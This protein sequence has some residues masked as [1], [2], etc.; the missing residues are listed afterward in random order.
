MRHLYVVCHCNWILLPACCRPQEKRLLCGM[1]F[2]QNFLFCIFEIPACSGPNGLRT[3]FTCAH[4]VD[5]G[6]LLLGRGKRTKQPCSEPLGVPSLPVQRL[7]TRALRAADREPVR[8]RDDHALV[9]QDT[10][11]R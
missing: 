4:V 6:F 8:D 5:W 7:A 1:L 10:R 11:Q 3:S 2:S 9:S